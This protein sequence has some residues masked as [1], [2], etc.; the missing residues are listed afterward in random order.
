MGD[1]GT[2]RRIV[3]A[4]RASTNRARKS[5]Q[6]AG[7]RIPS[8]DLYYSRAE[9]M[10]AVDTSVRSLAPSVRII[11]LDGDLA[12]EALRDQVQI[13][14]PAKKK[15]DV[16]TGAADSAWIRQVLRAA[17]NDIDSFVIVGADADVYEAFKGWN[18]PKPHM[19]PLHAL[20]RTLFVLEAPSDE[21]KDALVQFLQGLVGQRLEA[22]RTPDEDLI[23]GDVAVLTELVD[24]WEDD[25]IRDVELGRIR[26]VV[27]MNQ[28]KIRRRG[29]VGLGQVGIGSGMSR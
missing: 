8:D 22:G 20:Q 15:S 23:L 29:L 18:R 7:L 3:E 1:R 26:A 5:M 11:A 2:R 19:V 17:D 25:Q 16:K 28:V 21:I 24:D 4:W 9:V 13:R 12:V 10:A 6:A 27:G 14:P